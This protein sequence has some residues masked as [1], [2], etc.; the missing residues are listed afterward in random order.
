MAL[1]RRKKYDP[2]SYDSVRSYNYDPF[3]NSEIYYM[4]LRAKRR[5][6]RKQLILIAIAVVLVVIAIITIVTIVRQNNKESKDNHNGTSIAQIDSRTENYEPA[7]VSESTDKTPEQPSFNEETQKEEN[8]IGFVNVDY[9]V[10]VEQSTGED[11]TIQY[12][13]YGVRL[14]QTQRE[15]YY[16]FVSTI[17]QLETSLIFHNTESDDIIQAYEAVLN[18]YPEFYWLAGGCS[19]QEQTIGTS[20]TIWFELDTIHDVE[21][22]RAQRRD[23]EDVCHGIVSD[24]AGMSLYDTVLYIHDYLVE[25]TTYDIETYLYIAEGDLNVSGTAYGC[26]INHL[27]VCSGYAKAFQWLMKLSGVECLRVSGYDA[28]TGDSHE[29]NCVKLAGDY[30]Y[31]DVTWDDPMHPDGGE[32]S[33]AHDYFCITTSELLETHIIENGQEEPHC[34]ATSYDYYKMRGLYYDTYSYAQIRDA[35]D[36]LIAQGMT[37]LSAKFGNADECDRAM[38]DLLDNHL[39]FEI[40]GIGANVSYT[41]SKNHRILT[42]T[43]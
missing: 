20:N 36:Q 17:D 15:I 34:T 26:L 40:D 30:Y 14:N 7:P 4:Q 37:E 33:L 32:E 11:L 19:W 5:R 9:D 16:D 18:D 2:Y 42:I 1:K 35:F 13:Y 31:V 24:T 8:E 27:A 6:K 43:I 41:I 25:N 21:K 23:V 10:T 28:Y 38:E 39:I 29:W 3:E 22:I 12:G